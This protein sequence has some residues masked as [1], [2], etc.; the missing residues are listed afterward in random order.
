METP[1]TFLNQINSS[2]FDDYF[3]L[4]GNKEV[5][6]LITGRALTKEE[7]E[8]KF[9]E[10]L[11]INLKST[12]S[13]Y[14]GIH[15]ISTGEFIGL[16]KIVMTD[17]DEAEIGYVFLPEHWNKGYGGEVSEKLVSHSMN[18]KNIKSLIAIIDPENVASKKI[19]MKS[20]FLLE[21]I[22]E[23]EGLPAEIYRLEFP[24]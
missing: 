11:N 20:G 9:N 5:M 10:I 8:R 6:R 13:G 7:A 3:K 2:D 4:Y 19:L 14:F 17:N 1:R 23:I 15:L 22:C 16:G 21:R 12:E 24:L 18:I